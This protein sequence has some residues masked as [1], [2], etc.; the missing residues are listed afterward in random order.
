MELY[1]IRHGQSANNVI[2]MAYSDYE[3]RRDVDPPLTALGQQQAEATARYLAEAVNLE[4]LV[5]QPAENRAEMPTGFDIT[6]LYSSPMLRALQTAQPIGQALGLPVEVW[7]DVHEHGGMYLR[8]PDERGVVGFPGRSR[9]E[10]LADFPDYILPDS[11]T[12]AGWWNPASKEEDIAGCFARAVRVAAAL[13]RRAHSQERIAIVTHGTFS[14]CLL[15][16][17]LNMLPSD[18]LHYRLYNTG[19]T[20]LDFR[21]DGHVIVW[22]I[23]R[24][25]H[26]PPAL[27]S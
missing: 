1:L 4:T 22:Y 10:I 8:Y 16:A 12:E 17:L 20:R 24:V 21:A 9:A 19:I 6:R 23:N 3:H 5:E 13:R 25:H 11:I 27:V 2:M 14:D 18:H 7:P 15:K 26:L